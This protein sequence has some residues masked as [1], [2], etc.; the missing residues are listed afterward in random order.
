MQA[1]ASLE[2][3]TGL[4]HPDSPT[5]TPSAVAL[6]QTTCTPPAC[7]PLPSLRTHHRCT[8]LACTHTRTQSCHAPI[9]QRTGVLGPWSTPA[10]P[11]PR[12]HRGPPRAGVDAMGSGGGGGALSGHRQL[13]HPGPSGCSLVSVIPMN[14][15]VPCNRSYGNCGGDP[16][17]KATGVPGQPLPCRQGDAEVFA[18]GGGGGTGSTHR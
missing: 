7:T 17:T 13:C 1:K 6:Y 14:F 4:I 10:W 2:A 15:P 5:C 9:S 12:R 3:G 18:G 11:R 8:P 16:V